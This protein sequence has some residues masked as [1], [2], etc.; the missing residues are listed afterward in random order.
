LGEVVATSEPTPG[1]IEALLDSALAALQAVDGATARACL[2]LA[3]RGLSRFGSDELL[4][5]RRRALHHEIAVDGHV[6]ALGAFDKARR[7]EL[8]AGPDSPEVFAATL[9]VAVMLSVF[10]HFDEALEVLRRQYARITRLPVGSRATY[11]Q[12]LRMRV[13]VT[14]HKRAVALGRSDDLD[15]AERILMCDAGDR[16][17]S[18]PEPADLDRMMAQISLARGELAERYGRRGAATA[19][20][21]AAGLLAT[22]PGAVVEFDPNRGS[23][24]GQFRVDVRWA[25]VAMGAA[26]HTEDRAL[27]ERAA[28]V[29]IG[30]W[31]SSPTVPAF[32]LSLRQ[33]LR[34]GMASFQLDLPPLGRPAPFTGW[35]HDFR[36]PA[37][38]LSLVGGRSWACPTA[39]TLAAG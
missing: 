32:G 18:G 17:R 19:Y 23:V 33:M 29:G 2:A 16:Q 12:W 3:A 6:G 25:L 34:H 26:V 22:P 30:T 10:G 20:Q 7:L 27:F 14:L 4:H 35:D 8:L 13:A 24:P 36:P 9:D 1:G 28:L 5:L 31:N 15:L 39:V 11:R 37:R 38:A 21:R